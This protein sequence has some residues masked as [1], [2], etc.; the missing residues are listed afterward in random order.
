MSECF[1]WQATLRDNTQSRAVLLFRSLTQFHPSLTEECKHGCHLQNAS[2]E[3]KPSRRTRQWSAMLNDSWPLVVFVL[4]WPQPAS[5]VGVCCWLWWD[6]WG[7]NDQI[8]ASTHTVSS[9][10]EVQVLC[11]R[12]NT[13]EIIVR[14][15]SWLRC[16]CVSVSVCAGVSITEWPSR[17]ERSHVWYLDLE[18]VFIGSCSAPPHRC[19]HLI[20]LLRALVRT[21]FDVCGLCCWSTSEIHDCVGWDRN[22]AVA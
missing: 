18:N 5:H 6:R 17:C 19:F 10:Y 14:L 16:L 11:D 8:R 4:D 15:T 3:G 1:S 13:A 20:H 7:V 22:S 2:S 12:L 9:L 21:C